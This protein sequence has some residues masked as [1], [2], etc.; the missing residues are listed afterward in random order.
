MRRFPRFLYFGHSLDIF[1]AL[2]CR[3]SRLPFIVFTANFTRCILDIIS[4]SIPGK[5]GPF[6]APLSKR[7]KA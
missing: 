4:G 2:L 5:S 3:F 1:S 7:L 6:R